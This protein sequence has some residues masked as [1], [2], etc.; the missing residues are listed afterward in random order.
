[1]TIL[2]TGAGG[3]VG[4]NLLETLLSEGHRVVALNN[5]PLP[6]SVA[7]HLAA[8]KGELVWILGDV[9]DRAQMRDI[10]KDQNVT[11]IVHAAAI[12]LGPQSA[13]ATA[14][15]AFDVNVVSTAALLQ[16]AA[17][18]GITRFVYPSS[19]AVYGP[20][21]FSAPVTEETPT[22][23]VALYGFTKLASERL[24][25]EAARALDLSCVCARITAVFG[26]WEHDTGVRETLSPPMQVARAHLNGQSVALPQ[27]GSRD[28]TSARDI[29]KGLAILLFAE[30]PAHPV[31][32][33]SLGET[34][35]PRALAEALGTE[36]RPQDSADVEIRFNDD[37]TRQRNPILGARFAEE[38]G[39]T[40]LTPTEA[41]ADYADW[42]AQHGLGGLLL[43]D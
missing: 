18:A 42:L 41:V 24:V 5:R 38:F 31:Y 13:I 9:R 4:L 27:T 17:A 14:E 19:S 34:W 29:A 6:A 16:E 12:T 7:R 15:L 30:K 20:A 40:F 32:N 25:M 3:F 33:L 28:W 43:T 23:P 39:F 1:M 21:P 11:R 37:I 22:T 10:L 36:I 8:L 35:H 26:P 2:V